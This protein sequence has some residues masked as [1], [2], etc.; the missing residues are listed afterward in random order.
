[1]ES[2]ANDAVRTLLNPTVQFISIF[3]KGT[4]FVFTGIMLSFRL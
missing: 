2:N 4:P 3:S 1:M